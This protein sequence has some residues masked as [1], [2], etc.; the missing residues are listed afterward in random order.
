MKVVPTT[1]IVFSCELEEVVGTGCIGC[2]LST[3]QACMGFGTL[4][5]GLTPHFKVFT[6]L[7]SEDFEH[8]LSY[9]IKSLERKCLEQI[10]KVSTLSSFLNPHIAFHANT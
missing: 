10:L 5:L 6:V 1:L 4:M 3:V 7:V 8:F 9:A 2:V